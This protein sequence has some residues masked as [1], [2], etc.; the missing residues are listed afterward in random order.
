MKK[1]GKKTSYEARIER[2]K[3]NNNNGKSLLTISSMAYCVYYLI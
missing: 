2:L 3:N 1:Q